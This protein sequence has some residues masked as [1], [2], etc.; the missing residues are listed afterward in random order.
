MVWLRELVLGVPEPWTTSKQGCTILPL[1]DMGNSGL[2][3]QSPEGS[4]GWGINHF[5]GA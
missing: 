4:T 1:V 3:L 5:E 2:V